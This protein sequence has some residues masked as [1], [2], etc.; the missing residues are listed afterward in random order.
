M[1]DTS[2]VILADFPMEIKKRDIL[3]LLGYRRAKTPPSRVLKLVEEVVT[4]ASELIFPRAVYRLIPEKEYPKHTLFRETEVIGLAI[5]TVGEKLDE[6]ITKLS[7]K[8]EMLETLILD[9]LGS[10]ALERTADYTNAHI[11]H[12]EDIAHLHPYPRIS[13]GYGKW[14]LEQQ[15]IIF[16]FLPVEK[17]GV[18]LTPGL[19]MAPRKSLSFAV[20]LMKKPYPYPTK[21]SLCDICH[22]KHCPFHQKEG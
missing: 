11:C 9:A 1:M 8:G 18:M 3:R 22:L 16:S 2:P 13:P 17:I 21:P 15:R 4:R 6:E 20:R 5:C 10:E 19:I 7:E 14:E 12:R